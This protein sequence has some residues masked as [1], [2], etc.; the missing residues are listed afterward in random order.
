[1]TGALIEYH[2]KVVIS[3]KSLEDGSDLSFSVSNVQESTA[4]SVVWPILKS[5]GSVGV[6]MGEFMPSSSTSS[7][8][9][10][11][12][13]GSIG[14]ERKF[15][16]L[17]E[18]Y[19]I[20]NQPILIYVCACAA[21]EFDSGDYQLRW[22][23]VIKRTRERDSDISIDIAG[24]G[25][26]DRIINTI[27]SRDIFSSAPESSLGLPLPVIIGDAVQV[28]PI[29]INDASESSVEYAYGTN[30]VDYR[31]D[32]I[33]QAYAK[34][35][36]GDYVEID[37]SNST[38]TQ[39]YGNTY[40][41]GKSNDTMS[42]WEIGH[43]FQI[44]SEGDIIT[45]AF[46]RIY[47]SAGTA[48]GVIEIKLYV[49][50]LLQN[51]SSSN[52]G[53][54]PGTV[55]GTGRYELSKLSASAGDYEIRVNFD[56]PVVLKPY[57]NWF[58][59]HKL[60][61]D[62][63]GYVKKYYDVAVS[64]NIFIKTTSDSLWT[65]VTDY[66]QYWGLL[67]CHVYDTPPTSISRWAGITIDQNDDLDEMPDIS[68]IDLM[69]D[70]GG[71]NDSS[72][73]TVTG[74]AY[75]LIESPQHAVELLTKQFN[76]T[77]YTG[78]QF[79]S[80][81]S[82]TWPQVNNNTSQ[83]YRKISGKT[84]GATKLSSFI[85]Q[86]C[87][88]SAS[89]LTLHPSATTPIGFWAW[90]ARSEVSDTLVDDE[91]E[92]ISIE[93]LGTET[94]INAVEFFYSEKLVPLDYIAGSATGEFKSYSARIYSGDSSEEHYDLCSRISEISQECFGVRELSS[95]AQPLIRDEVSAR[96]LM[97]S[98]LL[99][100]QFPL[101]LVTFRVPYQRFKD[102]KLLDVIN[103]SHPRL[104]AFFGTT[105]KASPATYDGAEVDLT[106]GYNLSRAASCR[107]QIES[108]R[109][110]WDSENTPQIEIVASLLNNPGDP[111]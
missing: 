98:V 33:S 109:T 6:S 59:S 83:Y 76:G 13:Y 2:T 77:T 91:I 55:L 110:I 95:K 67:G 73:G 103:I 102:R 75:Q 80:E 49:D 111:T 31:C 4:S 22:A 89:R 17:L 44:G 85:E 30:L 96:N 105:P 53:R 72:S 23:G 24:R 21:G 18:R 71:L 37:G 36:D 14:F 60:V 106:T 74:S 20:I 69:L 7:I 107:A 99:R 46:M 84:V 50:D 61:D 66:K 1:M 38:S 58:I 93:T 47:K 63:T 16:D 104:P 97:L 81:H 40:A 86:I 65:E 29:I 100:N 8:V 45:A 62:T 94:I 42:N 52:W 108:I 25:I 12:S 19:S 51:A 43:R 26:E 35:Y 78:G 28:K 90:G 88:A 92:I 11:N 9:I 48:A 101:K 82:A 3:A 57:Q 15:S 70:V 87:R 5:I 68:K 10:D 79:G 54:A 39:L 41:S 34:A 64:E 56:K 32:G 27:I